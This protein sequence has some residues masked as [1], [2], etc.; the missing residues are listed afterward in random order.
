MQRTQLS[1]QKSG[2]R[3]VEGVVSASASASVSQRSQEAAAPLLR[4]YRP[5]AAHGKSAATAAHQ[6]P[7]GADKWRHVVRIC[8]IQIQMPA[9]VHFVSTAAAA[10]A[11]RIFNERKLVGIAARCFCGCPFK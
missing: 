7:F 6:R 11:L 3:R 9:V 8:Q 1:K 10:A 5:R 4:L 2:N